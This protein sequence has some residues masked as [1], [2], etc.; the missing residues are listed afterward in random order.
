MIFLGWWT[1]F[2]NF[3]RV[4]I[5]TEHLQFLR[6]HHYA[7]AWKTEGIVKTIPEING[8]ERRYAELP[9]E[10]IEK[11]AFLLEI[12]QCFH[13]YLMKYLV[14]ICRG[15]VPVASGGNLGSHINK[16]VKPFLL[17]FLP[18]RSALNS[19]TMSRFVKGFHMAFKGMETEEIY[20]I[21]MAQ[22]VA[23]IKGYDPTYTDK[24]KRLVEVIQHELSKKAVQFRRR[25]QVCGL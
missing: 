18:K 23:T 15:H 9:L 22:M 2:P 1:S 25:Q 19:Q 8:L 16:D 3:F 7:A 6:A 17:Y 12:C 13:P 4:W 10:S 20:N 24:V 21:P 14:M 11:E 5:F